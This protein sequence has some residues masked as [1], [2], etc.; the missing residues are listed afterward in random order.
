MP[1]KKI[2]RI[3]KSNCPLI[4]KFR[5]PKISHNAR[6]KPP[7]KLIAIAP[8]KPKPVNLSVFLKYS[9]NNAIVMPIKIAPKIF[10]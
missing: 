2:T 1:T 7:H 9:I 3:H 6:I 8:I 4:G 10:G 5:F